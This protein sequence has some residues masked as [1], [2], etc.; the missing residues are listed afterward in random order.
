MPR[1][2]EITSSQAGY[3]SCALSQEAETG[4]AT[5]HCKDIPEC[6][7]SIPF[8]QC[9]PAGVCWSVEVQQTGGRAQSSTVCKG[10][11][12]PSLRIQWCPGPLMPSGPCLSSHF[13]LPPTHITQRSFITTRV[14]FWA[15]VPPQLRTGPQPPGLSYPLS[16]VTGQPE[17]LGYFKYL[18]TMFA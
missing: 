14:S 12:H 17:F 15:G 5:V 1:A 16:L 6:S 4:F 18:H 13:L 8:Q 10:C 3:Q 9:M 11:H 7:F 2:T